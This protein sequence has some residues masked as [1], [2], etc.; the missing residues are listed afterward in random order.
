MRTV[1][2]IGAAVALLS[3]VGAGVATPAPPPDDRHHLLIVPA[4][5]AGTAALARTDARTVARYESFSLVEASGDDDAELRRAGADRRDDMRTVATA[6]GAID[7]AA[8]RASLAAKGAADRERVQ[9]LVQF[10][11]PPKDAWLERLRATGARV[12]GYR[13]EN[14]Y[15]VH[16][17]GEAVDRLATL[18]GS[19]P[20]VRAVSALTAAD[21]LEDRT[22]PSG[23]FAVTTLAGHERDEGAARGAPVRHGALRTD[24]LAL[25]TAEAAELAADTGVVAVE[26]H[27]APE[28]HDERAAQVVAGNLAAPAFTLPAEPPAYADWLTEHGLDSAFDFAIDVTDSGFDTGTVAP[29]HPDFQ[30]RVAYASNYSSDADARDCVGHGTNVA[31]I[32]AGRSGST[33]SA[34]EDAQ[35]FDHGLGVAPFARIGVSKLFNCNGA[36]PASYAPGAVAATAYAGGARISNNSWGTP[37]MGDYT[38]LSLVFDALVRDATPS[39]GLQPL[40]EVVSAGNEGEGGYGTTGDLGSA[41]NVIS[42]G[43]TESVRAS[44]TDGCGTTNAEADSARDVVSFSSRGPTDDGRRKPDLVAPGTHIVGAAPQHAGYTAIGVCN[45]NLA[46]T[47]WYSVASGTSQAAPQV[48]GAAALVRRWYERAEGAAPSPA[49]TK[50]LLVNTATDLAGGQNG[51]GDTIAAGPGDDQGWGRVNVG[52]VF[53]GTQREFRDQVAQERLTASGERRVKAY[54]VADTSKPVKVTLAWTDAPG[55]TTGDPVV[56]DLDLVVDAGGRT[57]KGNVF[58]GAFSRTGGAADARNNVESVYLPAGTSGRFAVTV[59]GTTI[60]GDGVP[61]D[62]D[63][64]DQD[65]A[66]VVSNGEGAQAPVLVHDR[67][68]VDDLGDG[69]GALEP[70][71]P[72]ALDERLANAG[73]AGADAVSGTLAGPELTIAQGDSDWPALAAAGGTGTNATRFEGTLAAGATC[74]AD[75]AAT[76][77]LTASGGA[78]TVP[79]T[80]PTGAA[81]APVASTR[82]HASRLAIPDDDAAGITSTIDV[83]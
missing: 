2:A 20:A 43:A 4:T 7:P 5:P 72:F 34:Y 10:V 28:L 71:E 39:P 57:Y 60:A 59:G 15:V 83:P 19:D 75:V 21:K 67:T 55:S 77:S 29:A 30:D 3:A 25:S 54:T 38:I 31:S 1:A 14:A 44:G 73:D 53:D 48:S 56:N 70:G 81:G 8:E 80:L 42:V 68:T 18:Q 78:Q 74:G 27:L 37:A 26:A 61:I 32:A 40:V 41:K 62:A 35:G 36:S 17:R 22:S 23:V 45:K 12:V 76:L 69:D 51:K 47:T 64:T 13:A 52:N 11:G 65:F 46:G 33:G 49:L 66:L 58:S 9:A 63:T 16:A 24:F 82:T 79:L 50:A 6:A